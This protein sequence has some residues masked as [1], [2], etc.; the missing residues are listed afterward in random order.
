MIFQFLFGFLTLFTAISSTANVN[1]STNACYCSN[2]LSKPSADYRPVPWG[3]PSVHFSSLN[4]TLTACCDSF[5]KIPIA[6]YD[7]DDQIVDL[8]SRRFS[9]VC[10][11]GHSHEA[12]L[13]QAE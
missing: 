2:V 13:K 3:T 11:R 5:D 9:R 10:P 7:I 12:V 8:L 4:G 1:V 6:L